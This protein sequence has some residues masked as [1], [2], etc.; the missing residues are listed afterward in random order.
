MALAPCSPELGRHCSSVACSQYCHGGRDM[1]RVR[2]ELDASQRYQ[3]RP[4]GAVHSLARPGYR[5]Q[6]IRDGTAS[7]GPPPLP[8]LSP[9]DWAAFTDAN[10]IFARQAGS[11]AWMRQ[12]CGP[13]DRGVTPTRPGPREAGRAGPAQVRTGPAQP[14]PAGLGRL[15]CVTPP[16]TLGTRA[17]R[18]PGTP[19][20]TRRHARA[21]PAG[22]PARCV[23]AEIG[24]NAANLRRSCIFP[25]RGITDCYARQLR[26]GL[27]KPFVAAWSHFHSTHTFEA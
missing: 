24:I 3:W 22:S 11:P 15:T 20:L 6:C 9:A 23:L 2:Y 7:A 26:G 25:V 21:D 8:R 18:P 12:P 1:F 13:N 10:V 4:G 19:A 17:R 16:E 14:G 27:R 5:T